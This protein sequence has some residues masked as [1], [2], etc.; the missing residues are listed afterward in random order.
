MK[1]VFRFIK[2][3]V[4]EYFEYSSKNTMWVWYPTGMIPRNY[5]SL[6]ELN[7]D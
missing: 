5:I 3:S 2:N 1:T 4:I 7:E 6:D